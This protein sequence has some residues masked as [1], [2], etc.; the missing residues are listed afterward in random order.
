ML[1]EEIPGPALYNGVKWYL[2]TVDPSKHNSRVVDR[3][4]RL[5][6]T[7]SDDGITAAHAG[8]NAD[9]LSQT[10]G[11]VKGVPIPVELYSNC[12]LG[13]TTTLDLTVVG[14]A[15]RGGPTQSQHRNHS[16]WT[17]QARVVRSDLL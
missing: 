14:D 9:G 2:S 10:T 4:A 7:L 13:T 12:T 17:G 5:R 11:A 6:A 1:G 15:E 16:L 8:V 3:N